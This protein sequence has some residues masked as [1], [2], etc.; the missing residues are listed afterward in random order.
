MLIM[1][2]ISELSVVQKEN[3]ERYQ[4]DGKLVDRLKCQN[5]CQEQYTIPGMMTMFPL[6]RTMILRIDEDKLICELCGAFLDSVPDYMAAYTERLQLAVHA[7]LRAET[8]AKWAQEDKAR[9][10][11]KATVLSRIRSE[12]NDIPFVEALNRDNYEFRFLEVPYLRLTVDF[13]MVVA[14]RYSRVEFDPAKRKQDRIHN[15]EIWWPDE[16]WSRSV[17]EAV[18]EW[19]KVLKGLPP[20]D[21]V[22]LA[23]ER[24]E[25][26]LAWKRI[27]NKKSTCY[28]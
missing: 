26:Y 16:K 28:E 4:A 5:H 12:L 21:D 6:Y 24:A 27:T 25:T 10:E 20:Y 14:L 3:V 7:A 17:G 11:R 19:T 13:S 9:E 18:N 2:G 23:G 1:I 22:P 15:M 8:I